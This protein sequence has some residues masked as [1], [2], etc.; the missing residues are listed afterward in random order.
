MQINA[1]LRRIHVEQV[2]STSLEELEKLQYHHMLYVPFENLDVIRKI[3]IVLDVDAFYEKVVT[4]H[5]GGYCYELNGLFYALLKRLG[6]SCQLVSATIQKPDGTWAKEGSHACIIATIDGKSYLTDVGFG[7][8]A[9]IPI[10]LTGKT[11]EDVSGAYR[12]EHVATNRYDLKRKRGGDDKWV[13]V[14]QIDMHTKELQDFT[15]ACHFNQ[16]SPESPFT[17]KGVVTVATLNGRITLS[18]NTLTTTYNG[19]KEQETIRNEDKNA[20][21]E[22]YFQIYIT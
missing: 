19:K 12:L 15:E 13:T 7:D 17:E 16:F 9:R 5:R 21:L 20:V 11:R 14:L 2:E 4:R 1:Y 6:F 3:P 22:K 18:E 10:P 8:S